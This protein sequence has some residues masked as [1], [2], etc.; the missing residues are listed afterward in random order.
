MFQDLRNTRLYL[1]VLGDAMAFLLAFLSAYLLRFEF[2][3]P[4]EFVRQITG[5]VPMIIPLKVVIFYLSDVYR[6]IWKY[7][8][9]GDLWKLAKGTLV[10]SLVALSIILYF[11]NRFLGFPRS[12]FIIDGILTF[13]FTGGLRIAVRS[14]QRVN[15][16][17]Q[18]AFG[19]R[20]LAQA[21]CNPGYSKVLIIGAGG[22]GEKILREILDNRYL[23][24][25]VVG[26]LDDDRQKI[27]RSLHGVRV[28]GPL[29]FLPH[30]I[31][32]R[33]VNK[34]FIA[35]PSI[36]GDK[37]REIIE[38]CKSYDVDYKILPGF[39]EIIDGKVSFKTLRDVNFNDLLGR[40]P[41]QLDIQDIRNYL[42]GRTVLITGS[43]GSI[44]S[45]LC[46]QLIRFEPSSLVL[47]DASEANLYAM[48][49]QLLHELRFTNVIPVL[50]RIQDRP[51]MARVFDKYQPMVLFH[52]AAYKHV[53]MLEK[54]P[55]EA[56]FNNIL[57]SRVI[58]DMA[59]Q[60][61][62]RR[63]VLVSTDKAVRPTNVMGAS[64]RVTEMLL[65]YFHGCATRFVAVR[66]GNVVGSSGSVIPLFRSQ[67]EKG[68][69]V[70]VTH[71][72]VTRYF[73]TIPEAA[74]LI[75]QA[76]GM[77]EGSEIFILEMGTPIK[78]AEM[79]RDLI[80]LSG[81]E[82]DRDIE[83]VYTGLREGEKLYEELITADEGVIATDH[84]KIMV[85]KSN[86]YLNGHKTHGDFQAWL[87]QRLELLYHAARRH[88]ARAIR[89]ELKEIVPEYSPQDV[90]TNL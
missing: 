6:G 34:V 69:P 90:A 17:R 87:D 50:G 75:I 20:S 51:L 78:I 19:F 38:T 46:R 29:Q 45:E 76:G 62:V 1:M 27:G 84:K 21:N 12:V 70:T 28:L 88:D 68:G 57:G 22:S 25:E 44:G 52:A 4:V 37:I 42:A 48:Q 2:Q 82:P 47:L 56:V 23:A 8:S 53:P 24:Y 72:E 49:M 30:A 86:G 85:L 73:M 74:Q 18:F 13:L 67:I 79:A 5:L 10:S 77:G 60:N 3:V 66:F 55:W 36:N 7:T 40:P 59:A 31:A 15:A 54:N 43:G 41:V 16:S 65:R 14:L 11:H 63:F 39:G 89:R 26:F 64:K 58:M 61:G 71:S 33:C 81:K 35:I 32:E 80:R 9:I 83:I